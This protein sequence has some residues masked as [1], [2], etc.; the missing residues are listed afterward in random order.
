M[1]WVGGV[2]GSTREGL[3]EGS[4][5]FGDLGKLVGLGSLD[6]GI[7]RVGSKDK[8]FANWEMGMVVVE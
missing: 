8:G 1:D 3:R 7:V 5:G 4:V 2:G 6:G